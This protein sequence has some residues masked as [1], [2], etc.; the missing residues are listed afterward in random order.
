M[1][2]LIDR[3]AMIVSPGQE[4]RMGALIFLLLR[5]P[6]PAPMGL[7]ARRRVRCPRAAPANCRMTSTFCRGSTVT[8]RRPNRQ[9]K[10]I[11]ATAAS[12]TREQ[13]V[14]LQ[15]AHGSISAGAGPPVTQPPQGFGF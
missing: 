2:L 10:G 3:L 6:C 11:I 5:L 14:I 15:S 9:A 4:R 1:A 8:F 12:M 7:A 13:S